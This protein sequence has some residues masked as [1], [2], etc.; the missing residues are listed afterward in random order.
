M[1]DLKSKSSQGKGVVKA[2]LA[3]APILS[4]VYL[5]HD[6]QNQ[7]IYIGKAKNIKNRLSQYT[8]ELSGK[9]AIM[10]SQICS[11]DY[12]IT[13]TES[14]ALILESRLIKKHQPKFNILLKDDKSFAYIKLRTDTKYPQILK[15]RGNNLSGGKFF[16]PFASVEYIDN[17]IKELQKIFKLRGCSDNYFKN[18][19]R[20][21][22][23]H[24]IERCSAPCV[25]KISD[26]EYLDLVNQA[27]SFLEGKTQDV[28]KQLSRQ[29]E[30]LSEDM[31]FEDAAKIRDRIKAISYIQ[32]KS[33]TVNVKDADFIGISQNRDYV[34]VYVNM[35]RAGHN[36]GGKAYYP[37]QTD[38]EE[39]NKILHSFLLQFYQNR[40]PPQKIYLSHN[41]QETG[42]AAKALGEQHN[43]KVLITM[44]R[45]K[46]HKLVMNN[47]ILNA[48]Q[49][50][51]VLGDDNVNHIYSQIKEL[52]HLTIIPSRIEVYDNSHIQ[53]FHPVGA[54]IVA[55]QDGFQKK[56]YRLFN[57]R[58]SKSSTRNINDDY[59]I[60]REVIIRRLKRLKGCS[61]NK[62][63]DLMII[64]GGLGHMSTVEKVMNE[65]SMSVPFVCMSKGKER[66]SVEE[67]FHMPNYTSFT[68]DKK[69]D[70]MKYLQILRDE[71]HRFVITTHRKKRS[72]AITISSLDDIPGIGVKRKK[73]LL[74]YFGSIEAIKG[75]SIDEISRLDGIS[76]S[77]AKEI[78]TH[79]TQK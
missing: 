63:P 14:A 37:K 25:H 50:F 4:G 54:M 47:V 74:H 2:Y 10:V 71:A 66:N 27:L 12:Q 46:E 58:S 28:Q 5:M 55:C 21:C 15:Y 8:Q 39:L 9:T 59:A 51:G 31:K 78:L 29:M 45:L 49:A 7:I 24:Y 40:K 26:K 16:G 75:S 3:H 61:G 23:Q 70:V 62:V 48:N 72:R 56:E 53:G 11:I 33:T 43:C 41:T 44:P 79:L 17:V 18:C 38:G 60:L 30:Q 36:C 13:D 32:T 20:P 64:D 57:P 22:L 67:N 35:Y 42:L 52:F 65:L 19:T 73:M 1:V 34:C 6:H 77:S 69:S 76:T 68:L